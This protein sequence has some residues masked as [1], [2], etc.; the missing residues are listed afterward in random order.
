MD[1]GDVEKL[2]QPDSGIVRHRGKI[3]SAIHNAQLVLA[4]QAEHDSLAA[5]LWG[6]MPDKAP[7]V[8]EWK[9]AC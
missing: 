5:Y 9:C 3:M 4:I 2:L 7:V 8:N 1:D 6:M